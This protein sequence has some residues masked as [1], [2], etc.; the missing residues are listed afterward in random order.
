MIQRAML[1]A[2]ADV[3]PVGHPQLRLAKACGAILG[4]SQGGYKPKRAPRVCLLPSGLSTCCSVNRSTIP[5]PLEAAGGVPP[6]WAQ[7]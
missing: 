3:Q 7:P 2:L 4:S 5:Q 1:A 6:G